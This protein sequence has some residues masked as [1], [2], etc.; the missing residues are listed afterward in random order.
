MARLLKNAMMAT[1]NEAT[2]AVRARNFINRK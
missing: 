2:A 1:I